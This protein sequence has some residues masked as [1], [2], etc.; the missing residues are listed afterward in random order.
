ML[1]I[2]GTCTIKLLLYNRIEKRF[3]ISSLM[4]FHLALN[5]TTAFNNTSNPN[6]TR[7]WHFYVILIFL[8]CNIFVWI[9]CLMVL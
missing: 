4:L 6:Y 3:R 1:R 8:V 9:L 5:N 2:S 7:A